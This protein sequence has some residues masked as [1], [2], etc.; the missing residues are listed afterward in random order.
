MTKL[1]FDLKSSKPVSI[2]STVKKISVDPKNVEVGQF[3]F[4]DSLYLLKF[5]LDLLDSEGVVLGQAVG[6][7]SSEISDL[8]HDVQTTGDVD[9]KFIVSDLQTAESSTEGVQEINVGLR[10]LGEVQKLEVVLTHEQ[11]EQLAK[12]VKPLA[13]LGHQFD[14]LK[15]QVKNKAEEIKMKQQE[16]FKHIKEQACET[17]DKVKTKIKNKDFSKKEAAALGAGAVILLAALFRK[18]K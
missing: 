4:Y 18:N 8:I 10:K 13:D 1:I 9:W 15:E 12:I 11:K 5:K 2:T 7:S 6:F 16:E 17:F 3:E 14:R